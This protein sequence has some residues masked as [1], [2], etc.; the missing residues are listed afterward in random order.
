MLVV[1]ELQA[2]EE[3]VAVELSVTTLLKMCR[4]MSLWK[5]DAVNK[6]LKS[7]IVSQIIQPRI[8]LEEN[9]TIRTFA[10]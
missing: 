8:D 1:W 10:V 2:A 5:A 9:K 7:G 6:I 3:V 4:A